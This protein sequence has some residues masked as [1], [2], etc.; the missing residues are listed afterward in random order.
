MRKTNSIDLRNEAPPYPPPYHSHRHLQR[1]HQRGKQPHMKTLPYGFIVC[2]FAVFFRILTWTPQDITE[3]Q[4]IPLILQGNTDYYGSIVYAFYVSTNLLLAYAM[5]AFIVWPTTDTRV[6]SHVRNYTTHTRH[7]YR[8]AT[9]VLG[10]VIVVNSCVLW[11]EWARAKAFYHH[12]FYFCEFVQVTLVLVAT[13]SVAMAW[14]VVVARVNTTSSG[15][16]LLCL[17]P[18]AVV[19][20][21]G[22]TGITP[23]SGQVL[24]AGQIPT[25]LPHS[26]VHNVLLSIHKECMCRV[27]TILLAHN[28]LTLGHSSCPS[29]SR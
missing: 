26:Y 4:A 29:S 15:K 25:Y 21:V 27:P 10:V 14:A 2:C 18:F 12:T 11:R 16:F 23:K 13:Y 19:L 1:Q 3:N 17:A 7:C 5:S 9:I 28:R 8:L 24:Q 6:S 20:A 22:S